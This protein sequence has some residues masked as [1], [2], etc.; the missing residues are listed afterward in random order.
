MKAFL[1]FT[2]TMKKLFFT[3]ILTCIISFA[4]AVTPEQAGLCYQ[5]AY[6]N[7]VQYQTGE[8]IVNRQKL[9]LKAFDGDFNAKLTHGELLDQLAQPYP[10]DFPIPEQNADP[11]RIRNDAFFAA[12]YGKTE[13]AVRQH[14]VSIR[15]APSGKNL[16][17]NQVNGAAQALQ[18]VGEEIMQHPSLAAY[19]TKPVGTFNYRVIS[20]TKRRSAH[21]F[22]IAI[23]FTLPNGLGI[24]WQWSGCKANAPCAYPQKLIQD[25]KLK[26]I[27]GIFEKHGFIWGGKWYHYDSVHFEY[28]PELLHP[29]CRK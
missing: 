1:I 9:P 11:G 2:S 14:L 6:P 5:S 19:L 28:R 16:Q 26:Q 7:S 24:Y 21:A 8:L 18:A 15:W 3:S 17:F 20:G 22:G 4:N 13:T 27:V 25:P 12:M 10:L 23:D 29:H